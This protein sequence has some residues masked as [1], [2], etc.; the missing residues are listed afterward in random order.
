MQ[1]RV[2]ISI[3]NKDPPAACAAAVQEAA[4]L[5]VADLGGLRHKRMVSHAYHD[6]LFLAQIVPTVRFVEF[7]WLAIESLSHV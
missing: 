3:P 4:E 5:A 7:D 1:V 2:S 6:S